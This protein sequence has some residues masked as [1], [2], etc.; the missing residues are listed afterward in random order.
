[1][2]K[3]SIIAVIAIL[4]LVGL[5][6]VWAGKNGGEK[7]ITK[8][9]LTVATT[10]FDYPKIPS[11]V[12]LDTST[13]LEFNS[14][15]YGLT[16]KFSFKYP[17]EWYLYNNGTVD[18]GSGS[19]AYFYET[20][21]K[22]NETIERTSDVTTVTQNSPLVFYLGIHKNISPIGSDYLAKVQPREEIE[23]RSLGS[24]TMKKYKVVNQSSLNN[25]NK[26]ETK[27]ILAI[28]DDR[29]GIRVDFYINDIYPNTA[30]IFDKLI[31]TIKIDPQ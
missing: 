1:M 7:T 15:K 25:N 27:Y 18:G 13:W 30:E 31:D 29:D 28:I 10:T 5:G 17:Q 4:V 11:P 24:L 14:Q 2:K 22:G 26:K 8:S 19:S 20:T 6:W 12:N 23:S 3:Q 16:K 21:Q 9:T